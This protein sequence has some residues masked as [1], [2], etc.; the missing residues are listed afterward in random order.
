MSTSLRCA[1]LAS[2]IACLAAPLRAQGLGTLLE[3]PGEVVDLAAEV[4]TQA[5]F[6]VGTRTGDVGRISLP[7]GLTPLASGV[8]GQPGHQLRALVSLP[9]AN[10]A[11][12][13]QHGY[14]L[15][16]DGGSPVT[17]YADLYMIQ[18]ATD[19]A[20]D[21]AGTYLVA[22]RTP[23]S[24]VRALN[25][26][27]ANGAQWAYYRVADQPLALCADPLGAGVVFTDA[28]G[29]GA[30]RRVDTS[31]PAHGAALLESLTN[32]GFS[33]AALDGDVAAAANGD[34][35]YAAGTRLWRHVRANATSVLLHDAGAAVRG[36]C[37]AASSGNVASA[38]G[39]SLYFAQ[40]ADPTAIRELGDALAPASPLAP[41][42]GAVPGRGKQVWFT[43]SMNMF[44]LATDAAGNLLV[45]GDLWG[46]NPQLRRLSLPG[47]A[48]SVIAS[49]AQGLSDRI[50][51]IALDAQGRIHVQ[52]SS[53]VLQRVD[54]GPVAV[55]TLYDDAANTLQVAKDLLISR[56]G[57]AW[58]AERAGFGTGRVYELA[59]G[60]T[61]LSSLVLTSESRGIAADPF[62]ARA[63][64]TQWNGVAFVGSVDALGLAPPALTPLAGFA[65]MNYSNAS[66]W[67]DG[68]AVADAYGNVYTCSEDDWSVQRWERDSGK[69]VRVGSGYLNHPA[70]L[71][72]AASSGQT[73]SATGWSLYV[74]EWNFLWELGG[75]PAPAPRLVDPLA[76]PAGRCAGFVSPAAG[77]PLSL[78]AA[79]DGSALYIGTAL[80]RVLRIEPL[81]RA[82]SE[83]AGPAQGLQG[84]LVA[85]APRPDGTLLVAARDGRLWQ[86]EAAPSHAVSLVHDDAGNQLGDLRGACVDAL[87]R[88]VLLERP[89]S[90]ASRLYRIEGGAAQF[91]VHAARGLRP[92]LDP[93]TGELWISEQGALASGPWANTGEL[94]RVDASVAPARAGH[95]RQQAYG[96]LVHGE[97]DGGLAF[98]ATGDVYASESGSGRVWRL[99]RDGGPRALS[100]GNYDAP[101]GVALATGTPGLAGAQGSS[102]YVL[103]RWAVYEHGID[104]LAAPLVAG[105]AAPD[106]DLVVQGAAAPAATISVAVQHAPDAGKV[107]VI[108]PTLSGKLPGLPLAWLGDPTDA[109]MLP[110]NL[111]LLANFVGKPALMPG[112]V[113][114]LDG[115]GRSVPGT[116]LLLPN[117]ATLLS[118]DG[119]LD[120]CWVAFD[121][122]AP[123]GI[124]TVGATAQLYLGP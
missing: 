24:G 86:L 6:L 66:S 21:S 10:I 64:V 88:P 67:A 40:G 84:E 32:P 80:S 53:G 5:S 115:L 114:V 52:S 25:W 118:I 16:V 111:D 27:S 82:V 51:G 15:R 74:A 108:L 96:T 12:L 76:P 81:T 89:A 60:S 18:D 103:D 90:G 106:A 1:A 75:V 77:E 122:G 29:S 69:L 44:E 79:A 119:W 116:A 83:V 47:F 123:N 55:T 78:C 9:D 105:S 36:L 41:P 31:D 13:D 48:A 19:L 91:L 92:A 11:A 57:A 93:L 85:L 17:I 68:D 109:R 3:V 34:I 104:G 112:F 110:L 8:V 70:G 23:S 97:F 49:A 30:L 101:R 107:Y 72:I 56:G 117:S 65:G 120:L 7:G 54:E 4:G 61:T 94:L 35:Y 20:V 73:P 33:V 87:G 95:L 42:L 113:G 121:A 26:I 37:V 14:L 2:S 39:W 63:L 45:G 38:S 28:S 99:R 43:G 100:A 50:E 46:A 62:G 59:P 71:A 22:S 98:D 58:I 102:L 124:A